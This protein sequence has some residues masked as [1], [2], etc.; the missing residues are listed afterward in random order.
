MISKGFRLLLFLLTVSVGHAQFTF[1]GI[2]SGA[3]QKPLKAEIFDVK[4]GN[5]FTSDGTGRFSFEFSENSPRAIAI[6]S[7]GYDILE[8]SVVAGVTINFE[9]EK[10]TQLS[11]V[12][13][14]R[15]REKLFSLGRLKDIDQTAIY[16][17]KKT[18][19]ILVET[20]TA[21][22][23]TNN[24]RQVFAGIAG[25][26]INEG[27]DAGL[28]LSIGGRGLDPNRTSNFN[29]RQNGYD[30]SADVLG[31]PE[32]Y[33][34]TPVEAIE[35]IQVVRGAASLQ[36]GSQ[37]GGLVNFKI[38]KPSDKPVHLVTRNTVGNY[39]LYTNFSSVSGTAGKFSYY[40]F[41][42]FK[43]GDGFRDNSGFKSQNAFANLNYKFTEATSIHFDYTYF[44]YLAQQAGGLTDV[45]FA[46]NPA[47]SNRARNWFAIDWNLFS[48]RLNHR[49]SNRADFSLQLFGLDASR[50]AI[51][52]RSNRVSNPDTPG[53]VRDL[54]KGEFVNWG[55]E[56]RY[57]KRYDLWGNSQAFLLGAKYYQ[58]K[59]AGIQG[60]GSS[61]SGADFSLATDEFPFYQNQSDYTFP[62]LNVAVFGEHIFRLSSAFS[63]TPGFRYET[64]TTRAEGFYRRINLD[65][66]GNVILDEQVNE[67]TSKKRD[68]LLL[69]LGASYKPW[70]A[71]E[72]YGN[73]SQNY[74]SVTFNDIRTVNPSQVIAADITDEKGF[75]SDLGVRGNLDNKL[76]FDV[77]FFAL[78]YAD[79]IGEFETRNPNGSAAIVRFR[80]NIGT[81]I[82][83]GLESMTDWSLSRTFFQSNDQFNWNVFLNL[84][85]TDSR[86]LESD[87]P[88]I[89]GNKVEFV[90]L[91]NLKTG[92]GIG[93]RNFLASI[94]LAY[95]SAQFT[96]ANNTVTDY[97]DNTYG[98]FGQVPAYYVADFS[99]SYS[100]KR[101]KLEAG[102]NNFTNNR[103]FTRRATGYPGPGIIPSDPIL[104]YT[105]LQVKL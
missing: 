10:I 60:P 74:R 104:F 21:N 71:I 45:M 70:S 26:T 1:S 52:Y 48:M 27:S 99:T 56:A 14:S 30:I 94:Q 86:Y 61:G 46:E 18:E 64:I 7:E 25:L 79:K 80:D 88:G 84:A 92:T 96:E 3:D 35:E 62:N 98:I 49:F 43:Q 31:Y 82:T 63:L 24:A 54:I 81:A 69:G 97:N 72:F 53:T 50:D 101:F 33:Y 12:V 44:N 91:V 36:Y 13:V 78:Y 67:N 5:R 17:G 22:K 32:S 39:G 20:L 77:S 90:P 68:F 47:Q 105:T 4:S 100:W 93:Y 59:N 11:E 41:Y 9:L 87:A 89:Q 23:A 51:G 28:Q 75:T 95:V 6:F 66:A 76:S 65:L 2:I 38:R 103:Y 34:A 8:T 37:F 83:Y 58:S 40:T 29:T 57:L 19:L 15:Q 55:A 73:I 102:V 16:A 42:N 85:L